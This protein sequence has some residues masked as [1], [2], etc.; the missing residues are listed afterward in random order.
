MEAVAPKEQDL[1]LDV[2]AGEGEGR[3]VNFFEDYYPWSS[4]ITALALEDLP[5]FRQRNPEVTLVIGDGKK[6][7]FADRAFTIAF[8]NAVIEH[9]G[10]TEQQ[11]QFVHELCRVSDKVF[12]SMPNRWFPIDSHTMIPFAHWLPLS[13]RNAIY[14]LFKRDYY[15]SE[16]ALHLIGAKQLVSYVPSGFSVRIIRQ[17]ALGWTTNINLIATRTI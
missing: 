16:A 6:M 8:S 15:A 14:R 12:I 5:L 13:W 10:T 2:G 7:P 9:V 4:R 11:R 3:G 1:V 17:R